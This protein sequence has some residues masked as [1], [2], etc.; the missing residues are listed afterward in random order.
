[1][2]IDV[3]VSPKK[4]KEHNKQL[5]LIILRRHVNECARVDFE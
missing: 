3:N 2:L 1:M 5:I 4:R